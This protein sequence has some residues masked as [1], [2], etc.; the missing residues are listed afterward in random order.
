M[1]QTFLR[2]TELERTRKA[3][4]QLQVGFR[5]EGLEKVCQLTRYFRRNFK[6][7]LETKII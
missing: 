6:G 2:L 4:I 7:S 5:G 1:N 3:G